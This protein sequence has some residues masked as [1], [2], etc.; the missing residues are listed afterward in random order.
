MS[1]LRLTPLLLLAACGTADKAGEVT[2]DSAASAPAA[3]APAADSV[4]GT[5]D[6]RCGD[7]SEWRATYYAGTADRAWLAGHD[8]AMGLA[9]QPSGSGSR[10]ATADGSVEWW[11]KGD[12][13]TLT[14]GGKATHC[15]PAADIVF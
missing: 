6:L 14:R 10:Y 4:I 11:I 1:S 9:L 12:S 3:V 8:T 7:K 13:A 2:P 15:G 5:A